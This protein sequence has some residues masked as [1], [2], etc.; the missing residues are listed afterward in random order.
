MRDTLGAANALLRMTDE[1][2]VERAVRDPAMIRDVAAA[3]LWAWSTPDKTRRQAFIALKAP[4]GICRQDL[5][6][7]FGVSIPQASLDL[8]AFQN[9]HPGW[10]LYDTKRRRFVGKTAGRPTEGSQ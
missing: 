4:T 9:A 7:M 2:L 10:L 5:V 6:S 1:D 8:R 3:S